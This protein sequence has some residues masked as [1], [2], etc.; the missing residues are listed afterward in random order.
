MYEGGGEKD[1]VGRLSQAPSL[2]NMELAE[3][4]VSDALRDVPSTSIWSLLLGRD[5]TGSS[6]RESLK[7]MGAMGS[8]G[9]VYVWKLVY[10]LLGLPKSRA[11]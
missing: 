10:P 7:G 4:Q 9:L 11:S 3:E 2:S 8:I 1:P 6:R 5:S